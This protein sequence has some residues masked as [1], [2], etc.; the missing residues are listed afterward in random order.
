ME[1]NRI[2][3]EFMG[4]EKDT[5]NNSDGTLRDI[6]FYSEFNSGD[7]YH[8]SELEYDSS[9]T[10]LMGAVNQIESMKNPEGERYV[11]EIDRKKAKIRGSM[12]EENYALTKF[13]AVL[14]VVTCFIRTTSKTTSKTKE[15]E[16][17]EMITYLYEV[18]VDNFLMT[19]ED[20]IKDIAKAF[21]D[22]GLLGR[23]VGDYKEY[24]EER[25]E[26]FNFKHL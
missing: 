1:K 3:A 19:P 7:W 23:F 26:V 22:K 10:W 8:V 17:V 9:W 2:I 13:E 15:Q 14:S 5:I 6:Y 12:I 21:T 20:W 16:I 18:D 4:L 24:L 11:V 25:G